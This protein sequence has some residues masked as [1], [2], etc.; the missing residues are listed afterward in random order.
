ML[1]STLADMAAWIEQVRQQALSTSDAMLALFDT[2]AEEALFGRRFIA[3]DLADLPP[4]S[5]ILEVGAGAMLLSCQLVREGFH[6]TA[7]EPT[8][9]GFSHFD[10]L[11]SIVLTHAR[12]AQCAPDVID[13][14]AEAMDE[15]GRFVYAFSINVMEHVDDV[16]LTLEK[17]VKS[18]R[19]GG[20]YR[21]TC[22]NYLF[23]YEPHF[24]IPTLFSKQLT[25]R[26]LRARIFDN[27]RLADAVGTWRSLNWIN[28]LQ[29]ARNTRRIARVDVQF[30]R[31]VLA[32]TF[33]RVL[34]DP[35]FA[36]RRPPFI[37]TVARLLVRL[38]LH[39]ILNLVPATLQPIIDCRVH[40]QQRAEST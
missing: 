16:A 21:F 5:E 1:D 38:R 19:D 40:K 27:T 37:T 7:L 15:E 36:R 4:G 14:A 39:L 22:P 25:E 34:T 28:V 12:A 29:I 13:H 11:R 20:N 10:A 3:D 18:L 6:V 33:E 26:Y 35:G 24:N 9:S 31:L 2:Y 17:I 30:N 8:G 23:P 32:S